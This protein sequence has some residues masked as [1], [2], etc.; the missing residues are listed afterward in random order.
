MAVEFSLIQRYEIEIRFEM[1]FVLKFGFE[2]IE[3]FPIE[4]KN[5]QIKIN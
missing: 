3:M 4:K 2:L 5:E 1:G